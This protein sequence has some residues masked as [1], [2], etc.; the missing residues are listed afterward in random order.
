MFCTVLPT[1]LTYQE[2]RKTTEID[3]VHDAGHHFLAH[4]FLESEIGNENHHHRRPE[5]A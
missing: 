5:P 3:G 1:P 4:P 2:E